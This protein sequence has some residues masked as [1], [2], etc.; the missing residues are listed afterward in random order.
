[1]SFRDIE[2]PRVRPSAADEAVVVHEEPRK[3]AVVGIW[4]ASRW[5]GLLESKRS[6]HD[7]LT[8]M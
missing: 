5:V 6:G 8:S 2:E 1:M 7:D 4:G 3:A